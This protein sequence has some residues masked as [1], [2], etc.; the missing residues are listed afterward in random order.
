MDGLEPSREVRGGLFSDAEVSELIKNIG[1][2]IDE[3]FLELL[4]D[5]NVSNESFFV[6]DMPQRA[7]ETI[8]RQF[9]NAYA[10]IKASRARLLFQGG[11]GGA[12]TL[13]LTYATDNPSE[14]C[15]AAIFDTLRDNSTCL[16]NNAEGDFCDK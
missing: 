3:D 1:P 13:A 15:I 4:A 14:G 7:E 6:S 5:P 16:W 9:K 12:A 2:Q 8:S 11:L 10:K